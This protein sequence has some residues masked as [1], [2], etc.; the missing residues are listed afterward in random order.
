MTEADTAGAAG[1][2]DTP[3]VVVKQPSGAGAE[4]TPGLFREQLFSTENVWVGITHAKPQESGWHHHGD[5]DTY[6]YIIEGRGVVEY[7][8][9]GKQIDEILPGSVV[10]VAKRTVHR[11]INPGPGDLVGLLIRVGPGPDVVNV[12]GP[13]PEE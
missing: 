9:G 1:T 6:V 3:A 8:P 13:D 10:Y 2:G 11:D 4:S 5:M 7:G 12:S